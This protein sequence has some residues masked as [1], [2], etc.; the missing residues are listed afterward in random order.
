LEE[1]CQR[2]LPANSDLSEFACIRKVCSRYTQHIRRALDQRLSA[3]PTNSDLSYYD[4]ENNRL[5]CI[6][7]RIW[8]ALDQRLSAL[9][10]MFQIIISAES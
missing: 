2:G 6:S 8:K 3:L 4:C 1:S 7:Q 5:F 10:G 9:P